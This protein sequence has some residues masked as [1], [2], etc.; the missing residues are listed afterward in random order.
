MQFVDR[1]VKRRNGFICTEQY[2]ILQGEI[3]ATGAD[4]TSSPSQGQ[5]IL[6]G[7]VSRIEAIPLLADDTGHY[8]FSDLAWADT[9]TVS[10]DGFAAAKKSLE[11]GEGQTI[12]S[13]IHL[14]LAGV[15][16]SV[17]VGRIPMI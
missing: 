17:T 1:G 12:T 8:R 13:D 6:K 2:G 14:E 16:A 15:T 4:E 5:T 7:R 10:F 9:N 11:I 3:T